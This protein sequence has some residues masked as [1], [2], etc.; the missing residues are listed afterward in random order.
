MAEG[1][2]SPSDHTLETSPVIPEI[3]P[4]S[5]SSF[6]DLSGDSQRES[7]LGFSNSLIYV[8]LSLLFASASN[9][10]FHVQI[11]ITLYSPTKNISPF[12]AM[13]EM[14]IRHFFIS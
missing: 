1:L 3:P 7:L 4:L 10:I 8:S 5:L 9:N 13:W 14:D 11:Y 2:P 12:A 6:K